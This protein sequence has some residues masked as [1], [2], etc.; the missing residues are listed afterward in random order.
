MDNELLLKKKLMVTINPSAHL[1][2]KKS[3]NT[4]GFRAVCARLWQEPNK[5][6]FVIW[7][8][9]MLLQLEHN[10]DSEARTMVD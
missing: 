4:W 8:P 5:Y 9:I 1:S 3:I 6:N 7:R 10:R 2:C